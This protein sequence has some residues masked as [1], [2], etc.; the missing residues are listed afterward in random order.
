MVFAG[1]AFHQVTRQGKRGA[2]ET[3]KSLRWGE[4]FRDQPNASSDLIHIILQNGQR[5]RVTERADRLR[6]HWPPAGH[7]IHV[8]ACGFQWH[9]NV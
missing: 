9:H 1:T 5:C 3:D 4:F 2:S 8:H 6:N 7:D